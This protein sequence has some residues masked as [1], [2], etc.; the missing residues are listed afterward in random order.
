MR[1]ISII[2]IALCA[3]VPLVANAQFTTNTPPT[4]IEN[5]EQQNDAILVKGFGDI[6]S[7]STEGGAVSVRCKESN[8]VTANQK[9]YGIS[10][11]L[12]VGQDHGSLVVDDDELE[13]LVHAM[14]YLAKIS[15]NVTPMPGFDASLT[16]RSG[17]RVGAHVD[18]RQSAIQL[19]LQFAGT[20]KIPV[21]ADQFT[22]FQNLITSAKTS[23]DATRGKSSSP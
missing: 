3:T 14:D 23:L 4:L 1:P 17:F 2:F 5:F 13:G 15:Y 18:H 9:M 8:N 16:T 19:Y 10:V 7:V 11:S 6:G 20:E 21:S 12:A 22:Q